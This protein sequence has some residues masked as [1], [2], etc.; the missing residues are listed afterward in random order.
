MK[1]NKELEIHNMIIGLLI[2]I[3]NVKKMIL[4]RIFIIL[5]R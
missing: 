4:M 5:F 3:L 2:S 1:K